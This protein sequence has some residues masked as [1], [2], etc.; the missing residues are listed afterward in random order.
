M[1]ERIFYHFVKCLFRLFFTLYNRLEVRGLGNIP[2]NTTMIVASNHASYID[3]PL[4]GCVFPGMLRYLAKESLFRVPL[5]GFFI[6]ALG[7]VPV[8]R[9]DSQRAGAVMKSLLFMLKNGDS[10]LLFP[11][12]SR[13]P[14]GRIKP[15]EA[16][17]A[18]LSVKAGVPVLPVYVSGSFGAWPRGNMLPRPSKLTLSVSR[19]IYPD[20]EAGNERDKRTLVMNTLE[21]ALLSM[22]AEMNVR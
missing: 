12:G 4:I 14:D 2:K 19:L 11:E 6:R 1:I 8:K 10:V 22:E 5:L 17:V 20:E 3:P 13:S 21:S 15:L 16:G 18:Y 7:A 9:E